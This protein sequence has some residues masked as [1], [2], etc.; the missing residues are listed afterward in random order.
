MTMWM[1]RISWCNKVLF[2]SAIIWALCDDVQLC[3]CCVREFFIMART[4]FTLGYLLKP[5][6][7]P[8]PCWSTT[9]CRSLPH[10][11]I[12]S[13]WCPCAKWHVHVLEVA[14]RACFALYLGKKTSM[15]DS[16]CCR[17]PRVRVKI[18]VSMPSLLKLVIHRGLPST[19][20]R[21]AQVLS[22]ISICAPLV[23]PW[24]WGYKF[25]SPILTKFRRYSLFSSRFAPLFPFSKQYRDWCL[26][27]V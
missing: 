15:D 10:C 21:I 14:G 13:T 27:R 18:V 6:V 22:S 23:T 3:N 19:Y 1:F 20:T 12:E 9:G 11:A 8:V 2:T 25:S 26:Y 7:T 16:R 17:S 5:G 4:W 24:I